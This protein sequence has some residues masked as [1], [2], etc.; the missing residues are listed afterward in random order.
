[1]TLLADFLLSGEI[2]AGFDAL[3]NARETELPGFRAGR[4]DVLIGL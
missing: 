1:M 2:L 4:D 3:L